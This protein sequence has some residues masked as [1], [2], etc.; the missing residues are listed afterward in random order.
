MTPAIQRKVKVVVEALKRQNVQQIDYFIATHPH[1]DHIGGA[2]EVSK[3]SGAERD[4]Q[5]AEPSIP[6][7]SQPKPAA[8]TKKT[9]RRRA[10][11]IRPTKQAARSRSSTTITSGN[12]F[13][14]AKYE[15]A[16]P[17]TKYELGAGGAVVDNSLAPVPKTGSSR[18]I[19]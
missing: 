1:P 18:K 6:P 4:R 13:E 19:R 16:Q 12:H 14:W 10:P 7:S 9:R 11:K 2:A 3:Q 8:P 17:G 15:K 5:G